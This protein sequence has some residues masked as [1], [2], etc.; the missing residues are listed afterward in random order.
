MNFINA[1]NEDSWLKKKLDA[2]SA[3]KYLAKSYGNMRVC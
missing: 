2:I 1:E 3:F